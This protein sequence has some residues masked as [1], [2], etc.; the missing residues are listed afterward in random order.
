[1]NI[2]DKLVNSADLK[3]DSER[4]TNQVYKNLG[5][6]ILMR[7]KIVE[8]NKILRYI[9]QVTFYY[10]KKGENGM[11]MVVKDG[12]LRPKKMPEFIREEIEREIGRDIY[13][14]PE[15]GGGCSGD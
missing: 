9:D 13:S 4:V 7:K 10:R 11:A 5:V 3:E 2:G 1:M 6:A 14:A 15:S 12:V 8:D